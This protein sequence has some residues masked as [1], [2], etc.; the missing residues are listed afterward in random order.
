MAETR[1]SATLGPKDA[2]DISAALLTLDP[3]DTKTVA[4][5]GAIYG[6][7][8]GLSY[9]SNKYSEEPSIALVGAFEAQ[10]FD[11]NA[12]VV[13]APSLF[14]NAA[15]QAMLVKAMIGDGEHA[16]T[17][18][19]KLGKK[20]DVDLGKEM[21]V[22]CEI[23]ITRAEGEGAGYRFIINMIGEQEKVDVLDQMRAELIADSNSP[24][25]KSLN[26]P[27]RASLAPPAKAPTIAAPAKKAA[28]K[29][30]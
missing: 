15:V 16:V 21:P 8:T 9:R 26:N 20:V 14:L 7:A 23:G 30:K 3:K 24:R 6:K 25:I 4:Y 11:A 18:A 28:L 29:K 5:L 10:P 1:I 19:P 27:E 17:V 12:A 13:R 22:R 2:G